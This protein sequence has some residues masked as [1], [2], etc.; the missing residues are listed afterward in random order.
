MKAVV[1]K[2]PTSKIE[3]LKV[4]CDFCFNELTRRRHRKWEHAFVE[5]KS[6]QQI[7]MVKNIAQPWANPN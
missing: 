5:M 4:V 7:R 1:I 3:D 2:R 6:D